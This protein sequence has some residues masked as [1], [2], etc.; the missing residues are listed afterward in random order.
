MI[1]IYGEKG[2]KATSI[3]SLL[4]AR[5]CV[6]KGCFLYLAYVVDVKLEKKGVTDVDV[7][8]EFLDV[9]SEDLPGLPPE[10][11]VEFHINLTPGAAPIARTPYR[12]APT[13]MK[14]MMS[15]LQELLE[16]GFIRPSSSLWGAPILF[17]KFIFIHSSI[18]FQLVVNLI[19]FCIK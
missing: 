11:Q 2:R 5:K 8:W 12:L 17:V 19:S 16:K 10:R 15:Q 13:E 9:F 18:F 1:L 7:V 3:I 6:A 14:E 4:K